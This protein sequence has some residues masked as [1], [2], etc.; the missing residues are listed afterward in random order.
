VS[1]LEK[2]IDRTEKK[3]KPAVARL[4]RIKDV[5]E[6]LRREEAIARKRLDFEQSIEPEDFV[7]SETTP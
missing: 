7:P 4:D 6:V 3:L 1:A 5:L 2:R